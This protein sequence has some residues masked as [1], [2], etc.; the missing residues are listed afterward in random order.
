VYAV[1]SVFAQNALSG[2]CCSIIA[3]SAVLW[4]AVSALKT[5]SSKLLLLYLILICKLITRCCTLQTAQRDPLE[6]RASVRS[7]LPGATFS[8]PLS[9]YS[10]FNLSPC[11]CLDYVQNFA[12]SYLQRPAGSVAGANAHPQ[13]AAPRMS[14]SPLPP[15]GKCGT[16]LFALQ[17]SP[18]AW[19]RVLAASSSDLT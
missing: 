15:R 5:E 1:A 8:S 14:S 4:S 12:P 17:L 19:C 3:E 13:T 18:H 10:V 11:L 6:A 16:S 2:V 9:T 7:V